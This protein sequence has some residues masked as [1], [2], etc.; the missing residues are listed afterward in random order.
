MA[1]NR[2]SGVTRESNRPSFERVEEQPKEEERVDPERERRLNEIDSAETFKD[3]SG[4]LEREYDIK[5]KRS[6]SKYGM[7]ALKTYTRA[8][9][10]MMNEFPELKGNISTIGT[11]IRGDAYA[12]MRPDGTFYLNHSVMSDLQSAKAAYE[13]DLQRKF[14][15]QGTT[16]GNIITHELGHALEAIIVKKTNSGDFARAFTWNNHLVA[17]KI[18]DKALDRVVPGWRSDRSNAVNAA[19]AIVDISRYASAN[20]S[21]TLAEA[22]SDY[23]ANKEN[24]KPLS[25]EIVRE[26][27]RLLR[28]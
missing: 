9:E 1:K 18:V 4:I 22:V 19:K 24:A 3:I 5:A 12:G 10:D 28:S 23:M 6:M 25:I 8:V 2:N 15:P 17:D 11:S 26:T 20:R 16:V 7:D 21:E 13:R 14:H 27:K